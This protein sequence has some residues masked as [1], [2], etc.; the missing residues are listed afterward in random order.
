MQHLLEINQLKIGFYSFDQLNTEKKNK[1]PVLREV[2]DGLNLYVDEGEI[3]GLVGESGS[4]KSMTSLSIM[5]LL[6]KEAVIMEGEILFQG[7]NLLQMNKEKYRSLLGTSISMIFQ[8]PMTSLN[9]VYRVGTQVE[10][11]LKIHYKTPKNQRREQGFQALFEA[12]FDEPEAIYNKYP[13]ELSGGMRQRVMIAMAMIC[14]P[15]LLIADEPT[16]AL[17]VSIQDKVLK[18]IKKLVKKH[19][20]AVIFVSHDLGVIKSLCSRAYVMCDG[21]VVEEG[22]VDQLFDHPQ[23]EYTKKLIGAIPKI[24]DQVKEESPHEGCILEVNNVR[25]YYEE[26]RRNKKEVLKGVSLNLYEGEILGL[27]GESGSGKSTLAKVIVGLNKNYSGEIKTYGYKP[28]MVFQDPYGSLNP[29]KKIGWLLEEPLKLSKAYTK[30]QRIHMVENMIEQ[31]GLSKEHLKRYP[32]QLSGGQRQ[33]VSIAMALIRNEKLVVLD[34]PVSALDVT[35][36]AQIIKLLLELREKF[37]LSYLFIS[38][39]LNVVYQMCDRVCVMYEGE[40][41]EEGLV[42]ELYNNPKHEYTKSLLGDRVG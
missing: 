40:I 30:A 2:V 13:H 34:E 3:I 8:E 17:D 23:H 21:K 26:K 12:G 18:L 20:T 9:P 29:S 1:K 14:G 35:I 27:V 25:S 4:G 16:T 19:N 6:S 11:V 31:V 42:Q 37:H 5:N 32:S 7:D 24:T 39:D 28:Q 36:Q 38:H 22:Y 33:R 41:V 10:E 15:K